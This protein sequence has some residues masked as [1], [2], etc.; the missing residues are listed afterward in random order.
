M[1]AKSSL[2]DSLARMPLA[3]I[4]ASHIGRVV[5]LQLLSERPQGATPEDFR[6][7][8]TTELGW[9]SLSDDTLY[10]GYTPEGTSYGILVPLRDDD[11]VKVMVS[12]PEAKTADVRSP[13]GRRYN[14]QYTRYRVTSKGLTELDKQKVDLVGPLGALASSRHFL[15]TVKQLVGRPTAESCG[16]TI[17]MT[18]LYRWLV[19]W[20]L[21][22]HGAAS[23][24]PVRELIYGA[25]GQISYLPEGLRSP[26]H[27]PRYKL[28]QRA[29]QQLGE[30]NFGAVARDKTNRLISLTPTGEQLLERW[31]PDLWTA[32][33]R[34]E[35][36]VNRAYKRLYPDLH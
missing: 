35:E 4:T 23:V 12:Q 11:L 30:E 28:I 36:F 24:G 1:S 33:D 7:H 15:R 3:T 8:L 5:I 9:T 2:Q 6:M 19:L 27:W 31:R 17:N 29:I 10:G 26:E 16:L 20:S 14:Q 18:V 32:L 13:V 25:T 22:H 34:A 21:H